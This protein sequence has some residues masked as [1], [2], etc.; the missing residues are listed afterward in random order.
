MVKLHKVSAPAAEVGIMGHEPTWNAME[1]GTKYTPELQR[2]MAWH[3]YCATYEDYVK[4]LADWIKEH[5]GA[6]SKDDLR[7][8]DALPRGMV[9]GT[10]PTLARMHM[11]GFP[12]RLSDV[13]KIDAYI[14]ALPEPEKRERKES[15]KPVVS[16]QDRIRAQVTEVLSEIDEASDILTDGDGIDI[17][18]MQE[19]LFDA[20]FK[21]PHFRFIIAHL[22]EYIAQWNE[23]AEAR[24]SKD[25]S[26]EQEQ[27]IEG[28][29]HL[30]PR[31]VANAVKTFSTLRDAV[32][33]HVSVAKAKKVRK[34][35][36]QDKQKVV[37]RVRFAKEDKDLG[38]TSIN[39][40]D[41]L[42]ATEL[43][44]YDTKRRRLQHYVGEVAGSLHVKGAKLLGY[45]EEK[46]GSKVL[47][48]PEEQLKE[49]MALRKNQTAK[50]FDGV[51][52]KAAPLNGRTATYLL[53]LKVA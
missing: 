12:L 16:V 36:P 45:S 49:F 29:R 10:I 41:I 33:G 28:T 51:R 35:K 31:T 27:L 50:W 30:K 42:G 8:W 37:A 3:A 53:L 43:W 52:A 24:A 44:V 1:V 46:S 13:A 4:Y 40:V 23:I 14:D 19:V 34:K 32:K 15:D 5:R 6:R 21:E 2:G 47:R 20:S 7:K 11:Q 26:D 18:A 48:K 38:I 25:Q 22:D 39:P 9:I 17:G